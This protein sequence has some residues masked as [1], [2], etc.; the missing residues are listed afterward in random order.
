MFWLFICEAPQFGVTVTR[1]DHRWVLAV[2]KM[3]SFLQSTTPPHLA[4]L[5]VIIVTLD[6]EEESKWGEEENI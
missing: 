6:T 5:S 3:S 4:E 1:G 2:W